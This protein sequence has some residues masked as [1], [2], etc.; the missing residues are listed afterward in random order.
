MAVTGTRT[1]RQ[2]IEAAAHRIDAIAINES[3]ASDEETVAIESL[4]FMLKA[5]QNKGYNL[6]AA[7]G[8][9]LSLTTA[10]SYTLSP[11]RPLRILSARYKE[12]STAN[13]LPMTRLTRD[14]YDMLPNK[15]S[16][17]TP[18]QYYYDRQREAAK[19]YIWPV[20]ATATAQTIEFTYTRELED[21]A[22]ATDVVDVPG[23]WWEAVVNNLA[24]R[25]CAD[26]GGMSMPEQL[27]VL[28]AQSLDDALG[29]D[30]EE[31]VFF[32]EAE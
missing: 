16:T 19:L 28:A 32:G 29:F 18:T 30:R 7:T 9:S 22:D 26:W 31:S 15:S 13:E 8:G 23:E 24:M 10:A 5:W 27:P 12:S 3:V 6:W 4:D 1:V 20:L 14:E 21:I 25:L 2:I 11:V 17:G